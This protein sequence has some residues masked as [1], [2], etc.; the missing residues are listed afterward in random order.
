MTS[1]P[2]RNV[3]ERTPER[4]GLTW[5]YGHFVDTES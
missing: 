5:S 1:E 2:S 3:D 4:E